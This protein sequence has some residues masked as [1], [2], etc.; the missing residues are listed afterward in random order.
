MPK[1]KTKTKAKANRKDHGVDIEGLSQQKAKY[2]QVHAEETHY[3]AQDPI[4]RDKAIAKLYENPKVKKGFPCAATYVGPNDDPE[5]F[6]AAV[7]A[8][9]DNP[10]RSIDQ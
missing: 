7:D 1:T 6:L 3:L 9:L 2:F 5:V 4:A 8:A 10:D